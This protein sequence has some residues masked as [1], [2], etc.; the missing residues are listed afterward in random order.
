MKRL[1]FACHLAVAVIA[2]VAFAAPAHALPAGQSASDVWRFAGGT[3]VPGGTSTLTRTDSGLSVSLRTSELPPGDAVTV[4]WV[5]FNHPEHCD[6]VDGSP[7]RCAE[8]D[9]FN[10][11]VAGSV[12]YAPATSSVAAASTASAP[13]CAKATPAGARWGPT[14][15]A[16]G[17]TTLG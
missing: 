3:A 6:G 1:V 12:Q 17:C 10:P 15:C 7:F 11:D 2:A 16:P 8:P 5:V 13:T 4:W 9:L 14:C